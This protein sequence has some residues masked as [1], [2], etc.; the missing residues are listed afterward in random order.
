MRETTR[1][2]IP[3][4]GIFF[5]LASAPPTRAAGMDRPAVRFLLPHAPYSQ[6]GDRAL[7]EI[8]D[9]FNRAR[10]ENRVELLFRGEH[11][12][13]LKDLV[14][15]HLAGD[16]PEL[17]TVEISELPAIR[18]LGIAQSLKLPVLRD[19][20]A[21][22]PPFRQSVA[23]LVLRQELPFPKDWASLRKLSQE[24]ARAAAPGNNALALPLQ[25]PL[26]LWIFETLAGRPLWNRES[27]GLRSNRALKPIITELQSLIDS[28]GLLKPEENWERSIQ[29]F[30]DQRAPLL[31]T[32]LDVLP[33][34]A[35]Q[36]TFRWKAI[37][38]PSAVKNP[39]PVVGGSSLIATRDTPAVRA[40]V[41]YLYSPEI[42][43]RWTSAGNFLPLQ[44]SWT[45]SPQWKE[46][47]RSMPAYAAIA[48]QIKVRVPRSTDA[49][50]VR[51]H[52]EWLQSLRLLFT[53]AM[54]RV[55]ADG[56][57][58][59]MDSRLALGSL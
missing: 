53:D 57:L 18:R 5:A 37:L 30:L 26:G 41:E 28:P 23:V 14:A 34:L 35:Q 15:A 40:F 24:L 1:R 39:G 42:A 21:A 12:S 16:P 13:S 29:A 6:D 32:S 50:V 48:S 27:G 10:P 19:Y 11:F 7:K 55:P 36:T 56:V 25:G 17:A 4:L 31:V 44:P 20:P 8:V 38:L 2:L 47:T 45:T 49:E 59:Q 9:Q 33:H 58:T 51:A 52:S 43:R 46:L 22:A 3:L 54:R